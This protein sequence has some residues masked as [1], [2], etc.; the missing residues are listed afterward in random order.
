MFEGFDTQEKAESE[1]AWL[2]QVATKF[3]AGAEVRSGLKDIRD[4]EVVFYIMGV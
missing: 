2:H 1:L 3:I 4:T